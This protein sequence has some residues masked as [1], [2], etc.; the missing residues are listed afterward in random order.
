MFVIEVRGFVSPLFLNM[1]TNDLPTGITELNIF[2][3][4]DSTLHLSRHINYSDAVFPLQQD[5]TNLMN[6]YDSNLIRI[7]SDKTKLV[8]SRNSH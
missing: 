5:A 2:Q 8:C 6:W 4:A 7:N 1:Y 3:Y